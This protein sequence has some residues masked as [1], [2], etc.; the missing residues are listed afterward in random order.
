MIYIVSNVDG[1]VGKIIFDWLE[2]TVYHP[3]QWGA[4]VG[5]GRIYTSC[6]YFYS[7]WNYLYA[8]FGQHSLFLHAFDIA[9]SATI[10]IAS[11]ALRKA[12]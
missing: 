6:F 2:Y 1:I 7:I 9:C 11:T 5:T 8:P 4:H 12:Q 10:K 3:S